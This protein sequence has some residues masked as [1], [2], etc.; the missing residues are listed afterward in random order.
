MS[1]MQPKEPS[2]TYD[3]SYDITLDEVRRRAAVMEA[4]GEDWDPIEALA[5]E[6]RAIDM[7]YS[8]LDEEQQRIYNR[9]VGEGVL[10]NR[11]PRNPTE[12][13]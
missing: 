1:E 13:A 7:L 12:N 8:N 11:N 3:F 10:L 5:N 2:S 6:E 9:L 4:I